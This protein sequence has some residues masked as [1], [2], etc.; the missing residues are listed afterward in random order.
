MKNYL[1]DDALLVKKNL[2]GKVDPPKGSEYLFILY[3]LL[4]RAKG[5]STTLSDVHD[6]WASWIISRGVGHESLVP[7][8]ELALEVRQ[9]DEPYLQAIHAAAK[10]RRQ[11]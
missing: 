3:A 4:M 11:S 1:E 8:E 10:V 2:P 5:E 9:E 6:A 7:F